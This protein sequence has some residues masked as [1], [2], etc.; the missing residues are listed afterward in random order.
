MSC[1]QESSAVAFVE[2]TWG[3]EVQFV[4]IPGID[5]PDTIRE[6]IESNSVVSIPHVL[7]L[8]GSIWSNYGVISQPSIVFISESGAVERH[9][10]S[11]G[12][13]ELEAKVEAL[14]AL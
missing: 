8:T 10:G 3:D 14:V 13:L 11:L 9:V 7:D 2:R 5:D 1:V 12:P 6:W 4:G